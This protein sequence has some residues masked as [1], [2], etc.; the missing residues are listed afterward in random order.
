[1]TETYAEIEQRVWQRIAAEYP[2]FTREMDPYKD[3]YTLD[4]LFFGNEMRLQTFPGGKVLDVGAN[5]GV[6]SAFWGCNGAEVAA[7][8]ADPKTH[9]DLTQ[10]LEKSGL[11]FNGVIPFKAAVWTHD[12]FIKFR[13]NGFNEGE[14]TIRGGCL[15]VSDRPSYFYDDPL[16]VETEVPCFSFNSVLSDVIWD[17]V[18]M[19]I[20]GAEYRVLLAADSDKMRRQIRQMHLEFHPQWADDAL[21]QA[22]LDKLSDIFEITGDKYSGT[23]FHWAHLR[24]KELK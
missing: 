3:P 8:E 9:H 20:E 22:V 24:N 4:K 21:Y 15:W 12:G 18:K 5:C 1:M 6:L 13:G 14:R 23:R 10:M 16:S 7:Y 17:Y 2:K 11:M 19:D